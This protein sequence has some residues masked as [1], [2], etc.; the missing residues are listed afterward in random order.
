MAS[1]IVLANTR[2]TIEFK[3][4]EFCEL[5]EQLGESII[6]FAKKFNESSLGFKELARL[7]LLKY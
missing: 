5:E 3:F 6:D 1:E 7:N 4:T 2:Y